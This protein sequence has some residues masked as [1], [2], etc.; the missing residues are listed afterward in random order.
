MAYNPQVELHCDDSAGCVPPSGRHRVIGDTLAWDPRHCAAAMLGVHRFDPVRDQW[1]PNRVPLRAERLRGDVA[2][3]TVFPV[4]AIDGLTPVVDNEWHGNGEYCHYLMA[5]PER[6]PNGD[7]V[8]SM[9]N[10][11]SGWI[12]AKTIGEPVVIDQQFIDDLPS[13]RQRGLV[14]GDC[15]AVAPYMTPPKVEAHLTSVKSEGECLCSG[16]PEVLRPECTS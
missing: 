16:D 4:R 9:C 11:A 14:P 15:Y 1:W 12:D 6:L 10:K 7:C 5:E 8:V 2:F 13:E 3:S